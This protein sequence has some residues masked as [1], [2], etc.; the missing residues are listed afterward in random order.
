MLKIKVKNRKTL[1]SQ[2][3]NIYIIESTQTVIFSL[4]SFLST[5]NLNY[6]FVL[7][8]SELDR[9][10]SIFGINWIAIM[11]SEACARSCFGDN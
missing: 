8:N 1:T 11:N 4:N 5:A 2:K 3:Q 9:S 10:L 6:C 7:N